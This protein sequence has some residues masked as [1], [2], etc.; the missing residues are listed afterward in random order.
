MKTT[1]VITLLGIALN[2]AYPQNFS[3]DTIHMDEVVVTGTKVEVSRKLVPMSVTQ[4]SQHDIENSGQ[5]N[6]LPA[7][8]AFTP[9]TFVTERNILGFG[10]SSGGSG[11]ITIRGV[12]GSPN[13]DV[14]VLIDGHPQYQGIFGHPLPDAYVATDVEKVEIIRGPASILYGSNAM[15]GVINVITKKQHK[16]G[17]N[18]RLGGSYGSYNTQKYFGTLGYKKNKFSV[19]A[20]VN[21][22]ITDGIRENTD[23][24]I[25]NGYTK[26]AY[27]I[28]K[29]FNVY[30]DINVAKFYANDNGPVFKPAPFSI[31]ITR[32]KTALSIENK[33]NKSEGALKAYHNFG[34]H[35]LSDGWHSTDRN[36]GL[37]L[38]QTFKWFPNNIFTLGS[39]FKQYGGIG[40]KGVARD[41]LKTVNE[42]AFY[43]FTQHTLFN[44]LTFSAGLR[45]ENNS[46]YGNEQ[47]PFVG[48]TYNPTQNTTF[49]ASTSKGFRSPTIMELYL[50]APNPELEPESMMSYELSWLQT[51]F[52]SRLFFDLT[53]FI[54]KGENDIRVVGQFPN[55]KREN[56]GTFSNRGI[57][58]ST[59][60]L[61]NNNFYL[62]ANYSYLKLGTPVVAAPRQKINF[63]INYAYKI[64]TVNISAQKIER[65]YTSVNPVKIT[66]YTLINARIN[67]KPSRNIEVFATGNNLLN[68]EYE[69]NYGYPMPKANFNVGLILSFNK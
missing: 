22:N 15:S 57:E 68:Q 23:F 55:L 30:A 2:F 47:V 4:I 9:G 52:N 24:N 29:N 41:Q 18:A 69:I 40:N 38:Y 10:V 59:K 25:S 67:A 54:E 58:I 42:L 43:A 64:Y 39:D 51:L 12:G 61:L 36:S 27:T 31:D 19:F 46:N 13:T 26:I 1:L 32:G 21:R 56:I 3:N 53:A 49:K 60:Y 5:L 34:E 14:L 20:S 7:I 33:F 11:L 65:L 37:M 63:I 17:F 66:N 48:L 50:F 28:N 6:V 8:N 45:L 44:Q 16:N 35:D 62:N